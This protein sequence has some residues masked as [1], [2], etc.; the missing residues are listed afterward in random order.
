MVVKFR[1]LD[2]RSLVKGQS[3]AEL[4]VAGIVKV[5]GLRGLQNVVE[6][7]DAGRGFRGFGRLLELLLGEERVRAL[8]N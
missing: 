3:G 1:L 6:R 2:D 7:V 5:V 8:H 4:G